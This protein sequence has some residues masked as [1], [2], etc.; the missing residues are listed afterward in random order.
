MDPLDDNWDPYNLTVGNFTWVNKTPLPELRVL[1]PEGYRDVLSV[2]TT[3]QARLCPS[4]SS[5]GDICNKIYRAKIRAM[6]TKIPGPFIYT[7]YRQI[8]YLKAQIL[9]SL[10]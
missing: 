2:D 10:P 9:V 7:S 5:S 6:I 4:D 8:A 3:T 1:I